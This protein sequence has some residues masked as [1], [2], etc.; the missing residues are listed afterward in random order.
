MTRARSAGLWAYILGIVAAGAAIHWFGVLGV[1]S[2]HGHV[3]APWLVGVTAAFFVTQ[4]F[5]VHLR[6]GSEAFAFSMSEIP[7]VVGLYFLRPDL[8]IVCR[9]LGSGLALVTQRTA[10]RKTAFN[11]ALFLVETST[12][13]VVW[14]AVVGTADPLG[15]RGWA[16]TGLA[17]LCIS[18]IS[19]G[20]VTGAI[21][22]ATGELPRSLDE[23]FSLGQIGDLVNAALALIGVSLLASDWRAFWMLGVVVAVLVVAYRSIEGARVRSESLERLN[24]FTE[25]VGRDVEVETLAA[26]ILREVAAATEAGTVRLLL[27]RPRVGVQCWR[28]TGDQIEQETSGVVDRLDGLAVGGVLAVPRNHRPPEQAR[29]SL[30]LGFHDCVM[31]PIRTGGEVSGRLVVCD[32]LGDVATFG[33]ADVS[34]LQALA[35]HA[36]VAL[37][38]AVRAETIIRQAEQREHQA[39]HDEL[40]GLANRRLFAER[41][42]EVLAGGPAALLLLDLDRFKE[43]N[44]TLGHET[45]D[46]LLRVVAERVCEAAPTGALVAR[47]GGDEF[48]VLL[49]GAGGRDA[50]ANA[51]RVR[52]TLARPIMLDGFSVSVDA[53]V[54]IAAGEA[55]HDAGTLLRWADLAMS[56]AKERRV[57]LAAFRPEMDHHDSSRLGL[58][59][60]LRVAVAARE[61]DVFYQPKVDLRTG[62]VVGAEALARWNHAVL[63]P[64]AP[65][66]FIPLAEHSTLITPLTMV[67]LQAA[68]AE[69]VRW[70][71]VVDGFSIAVNISPRSLLDPGFVDEVA[72]ALARVEVP[73]SALVLEITE[74]SLMAD[75]ERAITAL[76][77]LRDLGIR[78]SVDDLG[79]GYSSLAYLQRLPVDEVKIDR[80]FLAELETAEAQA[81]VGAIVELGHRLGKQVVAEG[82]EREESLGVLRAM[83]CDSAQGFWIARPMAAVQLTKFLEGGPPRAAGS[84]RLVQ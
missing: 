66:E 1:A 38:N 28:L 40:T 54:G 4:R 10:A 60:D 57:G 20:L 81:V 6:L 37:E 64:I 73:S 3:T 80:S 25:L 52:D 47:L 65:D 83:G 22:I 74:T 12:A 15:P 46:R 21:S 42:D 33:Q 63:G 36:A 51:S 24:R 71:A 62:S 41:L 84:L 7:L 17:V 23:V 35:N 61:I 48:A 27:D 55:G 50:W 79:T 75:P 8:V 69:A 82:V 58:L 49:V 26:S 77:R 78:L 67:V 2:G 16:A 45:G 76:H 32:R 5:A 19:S 13:V 56:S 59:A 43:V 72:R 30:E 31:V 14:H 68:L 39:L 18:L 70:R 9:V 11:A 44:D 29:L 34:Q 53:S